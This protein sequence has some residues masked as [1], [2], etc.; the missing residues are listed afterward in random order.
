MTLIPFSTSICAC[1]DLSVSSSPWGLGRA[2]VCDCGTPWTFLLPFFTLLENGF[3]PE[4][5]VGFWPDW[6]SYKFVTCKRISDILMTLTPFSRS[7]LGL[8]FLENGFS[9]PY[10]LNE[11]IDFDQTCTAVC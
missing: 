7:H 4:G 9:A 5:M 3:S 1:L 11:W 10:L 2:A 8:R 6:H